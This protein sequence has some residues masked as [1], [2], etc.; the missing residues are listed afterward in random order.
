MG[1]LRN[2]LVYLGFVED[3]LREE[4]ATYQDT[5]SQR[6]QR[7]SFQGDE[8]GEGSQPRVY[9]ESEPTRRVSV[10]DD[11]VTPSGRS[12][13][14]ER[15]E[16]ARSPQL[17]L[18]HPLPA[19]PTAQVHIVQP[20]SYRD[21]QQIGDHLRR[22][23]PV[24]VNLEQS[25]DELARRI[26]AFASGLVYGLDGGLQKLAR[27]IYLIT[28]PQMEVSSEDRRRLAEQSGLGF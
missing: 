6:L 18:V 9:A 21:A 23:R 22:S 2:A 4:I 11:E 7:R 1:I 13:A 15:D 26:I 27:R 24:I 19:R 25:E 5:P 10:F 16:Y 14:G 3:D 8:P 28:P 20:E 12:A 17:A